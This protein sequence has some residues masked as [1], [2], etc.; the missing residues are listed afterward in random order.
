MDY[1]SAPAS[2]VD[3]ERVFSCSRLTI[4]HLQHQMSPDTFCAK[5]ALRS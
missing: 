2:S 5:M 4:N 3:A 1:L